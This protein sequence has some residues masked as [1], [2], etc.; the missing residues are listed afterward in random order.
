[1]GDLEFS[2]DTA[3]VEVSHAQFPHYTEYS[4]K[5]QEET[6]NMHVY[7]V[8]KGVFF[9]FNTFRIHEVPVTPLTPA[10]SFDTLSGDF[11]LINYCIEGRCEVDLGEAGAVIVRNDCISIDTKSPKSRMAFPTGR[12]EG[13]ELYFDL[14]SLESGACDLL[15]LFGVDIPALREQF[16][17]A[18]KSFVAQ[19]NDDIRPFLTA[20]YETVPTVEA[21]RLRTLDL[22]FCLSHLDASVLHEPKTYLTKGQ[23]DIVKDAHAY[24][25]ADI[26]KKH[27]VDRMAKR[28]G[29]SSTAFK[30]Y[31]QSRYGENPSAFLKRLRMDRACELLAESRESI[32]DIARTVGYENQSKFAATFKN[33]VG[34]GPSEYRRRSAIDSVSTSPINPISAV[35]DIH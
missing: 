28:Y 24:I 29:V 31:F 22:L 5:H 11:L 25:V 32:G 13:L 3:G 19:V 7:P 9:S 21:L 8:F 10:A 16:C 14:A 27:P 35:P 34:V 6:G 2:L 15:H 12:Y 33:V 17:P 1:M 26:T 30:H 18:Q 23:N 20:F 4:Y